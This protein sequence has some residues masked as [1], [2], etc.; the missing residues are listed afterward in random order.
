MFQKTTLKNVDRRCPKPMPICMSDG[1]SEAQIKDIFR[2]F[3]IN[4]DGYLS[5][6]ELINAYNLLGMSFAIFRAWKA[7]CIAD[8]NRDGYISEK[9]FHRL[10]K[11]SY[12]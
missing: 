6:G 1:P 10:L 11:T 7:L 5:V 9:E 3:D 8:E 12:K 4:G 2:R